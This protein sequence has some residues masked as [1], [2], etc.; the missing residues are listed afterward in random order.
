MKRAPEEEKVEVKKE[1]EREGGGG[2]KKCAAFNRQ[3]NRLNDTQNILSIEWIQKTSRI[4]QQVEREEK[5]TRNTNRHKKLSNI[6]KTTAA[7]APPTTITAKSTKEIEEILAH[8][9]VF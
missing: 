5:K 8:A 7:P 2:A 9:D 1:E 3:G 6:L 4:R